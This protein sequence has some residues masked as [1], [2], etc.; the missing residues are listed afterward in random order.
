MP[1]DETSKNPETNQAKTGAPEQG[2]KPTSQQTETTNKET[3]A[4]AKEKQI[5]DEAQRIIKGLQR[6]IAKKDAKIQELEAK[7]QELEG[8]LEDLS[9]EAE[10]IKERAE[11]ASEL[12]QQLTEKE[13]ELQRKK[14]VMSEFPELAQLEAEGLLPNADDEEEL[15]QALAKVR[16]YMQSFAKSAVEKAA[17]G[18][19]PETTET[20]Q[21]D[22][23]RLSTEAL[24]DAALDA[25]AKGDEQTYNRIMAILEQRG[26]G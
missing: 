13:R 5:P 1:Q 20:G 4:T 16:E 14:L 22:L 19:L 3:E 25:V 9:A 17:E 7:V 23:S 8:K 18:T 26:Q 15:R 10:T 6:T 21:R 2:T 24:T 12:E 11:R